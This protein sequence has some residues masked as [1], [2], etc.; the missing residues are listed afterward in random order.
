MDVDTDTIGQRVQDVRA[1]RPLPAPLWQD[2]KNRTPASLLVALASLVVT[3]AF[4]WLRQTREQRRKRSAWMCVCFLSILNTV[5]CA[6]DPFLYREHRRRVGI[7]D[8]DKR[9][10]RIAY[11]D[12]SRD[13]E[14]RRQEQEKKERQAR[15][16]ARSERGSPIRKLPSSSS[17]GPFFCT[18]S[19]GLGLILTCYVLARITFDCPSS[20]TTHFPVS[21]FRFAF[22]ALQRAFSLSEYGR[23]S[24]KQSFSLAFQLFPASFCGSEAP[25]H[26]QSV[27]RALSPAVRTCS[28]FDICDVSQVQA[29]S[30]FRP[31]AR[32]TQGISR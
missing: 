21:V 19:H 4:Y 8:S 9:P 14:L 32:E 27:S 25:R 26:L 28:Q 2:I 30:S 24:R 3:L 12:A 11:Q 13:A 31:T 10:F 7:A 16:E 20:A 29:T 18:R 22:S 15:L 1:S 6:V 17:Y 5:S 23:F